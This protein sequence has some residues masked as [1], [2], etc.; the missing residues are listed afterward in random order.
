VVD[1]ALPQRQQQRVVQ[2][3]ADR[4]LDVGLRLQPHRHRRQQRC[5]HARPRPHPHQPAPRRPQFPGDPLVLEGLRATP[6][7]YTLAVQ[8]ETGVALCRAPPLRVVEAPAR[9]HFW[10][11]LHGQSEETVGTNSVEDYFAY[12]RDRAFVDIVGHQGNDVQMTDEFWH[13]L[14]RL[15][16]AYD[17][18]GRFVAVP[19]YECSGN[20]G[21]D[22]DRN[23]FYAHEGRP[24][25]RSSSALFA[26]LRARHH[27]GTTGN[28]MLLSVT[29]PFARPVSV[30]DDDPAPGPATTHQA[31]TVQMGDIAQPGN[32]SMRLE[33]EAIGSAPVERID[34][35]HGPERVRTALAEGPG[36]G[37]RIRTLWRGA[38]YRGRGR[39]VIWR[40][41]ITLE[42]G[43]FS[44][45]KAVNFLNPEHKLQVLEQGRRLACHSV[46]TGNA[47]AID[48][49]LEDE[50]ATEIVIE[51]HR[52]GG[53]YKASSIDRSGKTLEFG[54]LGRQVSL[55]RLPDALPRR[56]AVT[57]TA[58]RAERPR[59]GGAG[60]HPA[61]SASPPVWRPPANLG[62]PRQLLRRLPRPRRRRLASQ[63]LDTAR[64][65]RRQRRQGASRCRIHPLSCRQHGTR[66]FRP[67]LGDQ[68]ARRA[69]GRPAPFELR[70][71][72]PTLDAE[73]RDMLAGGQGRARQWAIGHQM[74][75]GACLG[76]A[77]LVRIDQA[78]IMADTESLGQAGVAWL[79]RMAAL[80]EA[81]RRV[82]VP[83]M[84][85]PRGTDFSASAK[86]G[87]KDWMVALEHRAVAAFEALGVLMTDT[88]VTCQ[89]IMPPLQGEHVAYG[90][91]GVVIY[92]N[93]VLGA[94]SNFEGGPS[95]LA[96]ALT[97]RTPRYG[98]H[99][100]AH[101]RGALLIE[102]SWTPTALHEWGALGGVV[103]RLA[104]DYWQVPVITGLSRTPGSDAMK[105]FGAAMA[106]FGSVALFHIEG[107]TPEARRLAICSRPARHRRPASAR[108][109]C[110]R[111]SAP[112]SAPASRS[113]SWCSPR[114][115]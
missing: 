60:R 88:C 95:A 98:Y 19:G 37:S 73:A 48:L 91:T 44:R 114:R 51:T 22:G 21:M 103:G 11:D 54:G 6:G 18:P 82:R 65:G 17:Q 59:Q 38:E 74:Q 76:A 66:Q 92:C 7:D 102:L 1:L 94:C 99:L 113:T 70:R 33:V 2:P 34:I 26:A 46:T 13:R 96:A 10:G 86:L 62:R 77:D 24:I 89:T 52:G 12:A 110:G 39:E 8:N 41:A 49:W 72:T 111:C 64:A 101:R 58:S 80:P 30:C 108:R 9:R 109:R 27:D 105:H 50:E 107:I 28:R 55:Y 90:D 87:Q 15:T 35:F 3:A 23:V 79:E 47:A 67:A 36:G 93:S 43:R 71:M 81:E 31:S 106:S 63:R 100:D 45:A 112:I 83:T 61:F 14:N 69:L 53:R 97:G 16:A 75:V 32:E 78:H 29:G 5:P 56:L 68:P 84:T 40:C 104:G 25:R 85:D 42:N 57:H 115:S 20:T 4:Q